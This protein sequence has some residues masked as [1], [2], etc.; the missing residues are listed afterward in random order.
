MLRPSEIPQTII[1][2]RHKKEHFL[3]YI[4]ADGLEKRWA[5]GFVIKM[6][7]TPEKAGM[8]SS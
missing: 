4:V 1:L 5:S 3:S 6:C 8:E 2:D 7:L